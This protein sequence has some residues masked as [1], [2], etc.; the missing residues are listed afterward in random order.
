MWGA[1]AIGIS[2]TGREPNLLGVMA[3][4]GEPLLAISSRSRERGQT[5][6]LRPEIRL[7]TSIIKATTSKM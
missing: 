1:R 5:A 7:T 3:C 4:G 2:N 6:V